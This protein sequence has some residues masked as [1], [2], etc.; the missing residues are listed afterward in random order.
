MVKIRSQRYIE[1][2]IAYIKIE[3][4]MVLTTDRI[5]QKKLKLNQFKFKQGSRLL[6]N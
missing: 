2:V 6:C 5:R 3:Q 4:E 1:L